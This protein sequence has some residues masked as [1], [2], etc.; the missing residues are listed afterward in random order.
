MKAFPSGSSVVTNEAVSPFLLVTRF[1]HELRTESRDLVLSI[2]QTVPF[3]ARE[4]G[5]TEQTH[6]A[7]VTSKQMD[8]T[9]DPDAH[10]GPA[11]ER[12]GPTQT[13]T[14]GRRG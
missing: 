5:P 10:P 2:G 12:V 9:D 13:C 8:P 1:I 4:T 6:I 7:E 11:Q 3:A 14:H